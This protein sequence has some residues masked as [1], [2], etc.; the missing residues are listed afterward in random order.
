MNCPG[1]GI[2]P[3]GQQTENQIS[4]GSQDRLQLEVRR[5]YYSNRVP[6]ANA[7]LPE[8]GLQQVLAQCSVK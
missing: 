2:L 7:A 4:E 6:K 5:K 3:S 1:V 8:E